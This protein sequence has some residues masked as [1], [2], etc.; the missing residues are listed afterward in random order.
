MNGLDRVPSA[1]AKGD[2]PARHGIGPRVALASLIRW[3]DERLR[4]MVPDVAI[5]DRRLPADN[6]ERACP[7]TRGHH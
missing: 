3:L 5:P 1:Q 7:A 2:L 4:H 6:S